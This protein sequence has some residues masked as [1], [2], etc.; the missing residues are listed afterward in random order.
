[1]HDHEKVGSHTGAGTGRVIARRPAVAPPA[2]HGLVGLQAGAGNAA[3]VQ[4]LRGAGHPWAREQHQHGAGCGHQEIASSPAPVQRSAVHDVLRTGGRPLD[5]ATR[6]DMESRLGADFSDVRIH[7]DVAARASAAEVGARAYTSGSHVVIGDGGDDKHTLA[8][9]LTH[10]IQQR[11]GPVAGTDNG[12]GLRVSDPSD[13]FEREAEANARR[14]LGGPTPARRIRDGDTPVSGGAGPDTPVQRTS[15]IEMASQ[16]SSGS[17][18]DVDHPSGP[19]PDVDPPP[20]V[21]AAHYAAVTKRLSEQKTD[22][23]SH[24]GPYLTA[25]VWEAPRAGRPGR[26]KKLS[27]IG[28][29]H[30]KRLYTEDPGPE[31]DHTWHWDRESWPKVRA[32]VEAVHDYLSARTRVMDGG[33]LMHSKSDK[34]WLLVKPPLSPGKQAASSKALN[35]LPFYES[36]VL[37]PAPGSATPDQVSLGDG[38]AMTRGATYAFVSPSMTRHRMITYAKDMPAEIPPL[39]L[40]PASI[41]VPTAALGTGLT[42]VTQ[43]TKTA[44]PVTVDEKVLR[45]WS[46]QRTGHKPDQNG[47]MK[48]V[49]ASDAAKASGETEGVWQWLHL[50]AFTMGGHDG[51]QPNAPENLVAGL[52]AANGHHLVLEN[53]VKKMILQAGVSEVQVTATAKMV[54]GSYHVCSGIEYRLEWTRNGETF[55]DVFEVDTRSENKSM[56]GHLALLDKQYVAHHP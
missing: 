42:P 23:L 50:I 27:Q 19:A 37:K 34:Q 25:T 17:G 47:A 51:T 18:M 20:G 6:T 40:P 36:P 46:G 7:D 30:L 14:V 8:H 3:V 45:T 12:S 26:A 4:M 33:G 43:A 28:M 52:A 38:T 44:G 49:S 29:D 35:E 54:I 39:A 55:S 9:E 5:D 10:V 1:M 53:L 24:M 32:E 21:D 11:Q 56:G 31:E 22:N 48:G 13:R 2:Q 15:D 41:P 16:S